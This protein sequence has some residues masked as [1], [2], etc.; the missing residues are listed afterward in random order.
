MRKGNYATR[1]KSA[2][3]EY[4]VS[5]E[6]RHVTVQEIAAHFEQQKTPIGLATIYRHLEAFVS[7]GCVKKYVLDGN[8]SACFAYDPADA[9]PDC[10]FHFRCQGCGQ[11]LHFQN[12]ALT[13]FSEAVKAADDLEI[14]L[15]Q[16]V[17]YG[18]C[19]NCAHQK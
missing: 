9:P 4:L 18:T 5:T 12:P 11:L 17:F 15:A 1:Q 7:E 2:I 10:C 19:K 16:T 3:F 13:R 8:A 14:D 6:G